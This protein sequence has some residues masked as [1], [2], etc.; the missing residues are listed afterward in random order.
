MKNILIVDDSETVRNLLEGLVLSLGFKPN[1]AANGVIAFDMVKNDQAV[2]LLLCDINM[3]E[4][5]GMS[6]CE[7]LYK[8][9]L[10]LNIPKFIL[11][12]ESSFE[13]KMRGKKCGVTAWVTKPIVPE[14]LAK[15]IHLV[16]SKTS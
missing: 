10:L 1:C 8:E 4:L 5:D 6:F 16:L 13:M 12:T 14:K 11:T 2:D 9:K 7:L 3:P 15:A